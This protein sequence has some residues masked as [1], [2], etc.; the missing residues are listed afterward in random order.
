MAV[1]TKPGIEDKAICAACGGKLGCKTMPCAAFPADFG[2]THSAILRGVRAALKTGNWS[3]DWWE[4]DP[5]EGKNERA[6]GYFVRP[7]TVKGRG[8][9]FDPSWGGTCVF[10]K[11][12]G[13]ALPFEKRPEQGRM[14]QPTAQGEC[15]PPPEYPKDKCAIAWQDYW[16]DF[17]TMRKE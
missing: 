4:G 5:R 15:P 2:K 12:D 11:T 6:C 14:L 17:D 1:A 9:H 16:K 8:V 10:L 3:I 13:C 7:A